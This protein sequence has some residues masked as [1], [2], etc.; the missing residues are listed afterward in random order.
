MKKTYK[1][2]K[3]QYNNIVSRLIT[4]NISLEEPN[5]GINPETIELIKYFYRKSEEFSPYWVEKGLSY[6]EICEYLTNKGLI[7]SKQG[8]YE[9]P[10]SLGT[11]EEA[12]SLI[13]S[14]LSELTNEEFDNDDALI[15]TGFEPK[16]ELEI[17]DFEEEN[18]VEINGPLSTISS[19]DEISIITDGVNL[20][21]FTYIDIS[22][23]PLSDE[24]LN[25]F[26]NMNPEQIGYGLDSWLDGKHR[27]T[28]IDDSLKQEL[29]VLYGHDT[30]ILNALSPLENTSELE[31]FDT[32]ISEPSGNKVIEK[33][34][35]LKQQEELADT[36]I[37]PQEIDEMTSAGASATG[38]SSGPFT[39]PLNFGNSD[40]DDLIRKNTPIVAEMT[41]TS[42]NGYYDT[43][44]LPN[45]SRDGSFKTPKKT[46]AQTKTQ[47]ADGGFVEFNDCTKLNNKTSSTGC[48]GG[49]VD[50][51]VKIKKTQG[52]INAPSLNEM[53]ILITIAQK[54]GKNIKEIKRIIESKNK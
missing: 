51:V 35:Q 20:Y 9:I 54:T 45:I 31:S 15:N 2:T 16:L 40:E 12:I 41:D 30:I 21:V 17:E 3:K 23:E 32:T 7:I 14:A 22:M 53:K 18:I 46:K 25:N 24:E 28:Q 33:L 13:D 49:A 26:I 29:E 48:S 50:N 5:Q 38:G 11:P 36:F 8:K 10:K 52:N 4:E 34:K 44:A 27:L 47:W 42:S 39:A 1:I 6:D 19:N 37:V 43:N